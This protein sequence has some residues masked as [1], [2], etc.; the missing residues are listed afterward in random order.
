MSTTMIPNEPFQIVSR[1][2][3]D[4]ELDK[5][6]LGAEGYRY[7]PAW[8]PATGCTDLT[9]LLAVLYDK[10]PTHERQRVCDALSESLTRLVSKYDGLEPVATCILIES[11][12]KSRNRNPLGLSVDELAAQLRA[13]IERFAARL[14]ADKSGDGSRWPDGWMGELRRLS[15]NTVELGG[16]CF[17]T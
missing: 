1:A 9:E 2:I 6:L 17:V 11:L 15:R 13:S 5:L 8:S 4:S 12:R 16:P 3:A 7:L 10:W 14:T